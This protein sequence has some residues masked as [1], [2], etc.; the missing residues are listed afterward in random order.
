MEEKRFT[1][2][3][4]KDEIKNQEKIEEQVKESYTDI[5]VEQLFEK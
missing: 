4:V 1:F 5:N 2:E 3:E